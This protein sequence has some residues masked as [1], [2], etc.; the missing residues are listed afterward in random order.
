MY[1]V[2]NA[3]VA[4]FISAFAVRSDCRKTGVGLGLLKYLEAYAQD[5]GYQYICLSVH[6]NNIDAI[7]FYERYG[8]SFYLDESLMVKEL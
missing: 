8:A 6:T 1:W 2:E 3:A 4:T 5:N 7:G